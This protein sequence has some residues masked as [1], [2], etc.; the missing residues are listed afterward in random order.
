MLLTYLS[1][2]S[3]TMQSPK[4]KKLETVYGAQGL[5]AE[6]AKIQLEYGGVQHLA[7]PFVPAKYLS[8]PKDLIE[9]TKALFRAA[10]SS[11][12]LSRSQMSSS[13]SSNVYGVFVTRNIGVAK[14][15]VE[16]T[17][18]LAASI[19]SAPTPSIFASMFAALKPKALRI[20]EDCYGTIPPQSQPTT[21]KCCGATYCSSH[22]H[23]T[24]LASYH[25]VLCGQNFDWLSQE[26][27]EKDEAFV[28]N[29]PKWLRILAVCVQSDCHPLEHPSIARLTPLYNERMTR[30]WSLSNNVITPIKILQQ[31]GIDAVKDL[32]FDTWV[33][34]IVWA[35]IINNQESH[36]TPEGRTVR[37]IS[38]LY[39]F[40]NHSCDPNAHWSAKV[41]PT[42]TSGSTKEVYAARHIRKGGELCIS[43]PSGA[44]ERQSKAQRKKVLKSWIGTNNTC[45]C[46]RCQREA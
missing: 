39:S 12:V 37:A 8:R 16:D 34:Q 6:E 26:A 46:S 33:L 14:R 27:V 30:P 5:A 38:P 23:S 7:Y 1:L 3:P 10:S 9:S 19:V 11:C 43:Y 36:T 42:C 35:R 21:S 4:K 2:K 28:L 41:S 29:G 20:C 44:Q 15:L 40:F 25:K 22:C 32:R 45:R 17:T 24:A 18:I 31:L 13:A